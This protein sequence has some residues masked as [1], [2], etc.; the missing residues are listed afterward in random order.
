M[1]ALKTR[2]DPGTRQLSAILG[3]FLGL[4]A[5]IATGTD[6]SSPSALGSD[7]VAVSLPAPARR[8][9]ALAPHLAENLYAAGAG[10]RLVGTVEYSDYPPAASRVPRIG[11]YNSISIEAIVAMRPDLVLAWHS[12]NGD[13]LIRRLRE[14]GMPVYAEEIRTLNDIPASLR[15]LGHLAGTAE[16]GAARATQ[17]ETTLESLRRETRGD[18]PLRVFYQVWHDPLQTVGAGHLIS[19]VIALCGGKNLFADTR[20]LAPRVSRE[21][22]IARNPQ[23]I[24]ASG[25][26]EGVDAWFEPWRSV[27]SLAATRRGALYLLNPDLIERP[28]PR[29]AEGAQQLCEALEHAREARADD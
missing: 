3:L 2:H 29:I 17:L 28:T 1:P 24:L 7:G 15:T 4:A 20:G 8:I 11:G 6:R 12:G 27:T 25:S 18:A 23:V 5:S 22:V 16:T 14:L 26:S 19:E 21:A 13:T 9:V 10:D